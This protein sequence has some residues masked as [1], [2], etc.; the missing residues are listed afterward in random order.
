MKNIYAIML[1]ISLIWVMPQQSHSQIVKTS[2][3]V[4]VA[5]DNNSTIEGLYIYPNPVTNGRIFITSQKKLAKEVEI[6]DVLG[7]KIVAVEL[8]D[9]SLDVSQLSPGV[10]ILKIKEG[11]ASATRKLV[12]R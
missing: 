12:I 7:K 6:F 4:S 9:R 5:P 2:N 3:T 10:Y 11:E 8:F 1:F